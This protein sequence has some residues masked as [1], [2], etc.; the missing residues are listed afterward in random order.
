[1]HMD[2]RNFLGAGGAALAALALPKALKAA[3]CPSPTTADR[4]G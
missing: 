4:Y 1:M 3:A 2:R